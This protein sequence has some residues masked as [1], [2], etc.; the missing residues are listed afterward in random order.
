MP[1][2]VRRARYAAFTSPSVKAGSTTQPG[3]SHPATLKPGTCM[4]RA[5]PSTGATT[6][7]GMQ[8][9]AM[10]T[11]ITHQS[12]HRFLY[13][14]ATIPAGTPARMEIAMPMTPSWRETGNDWAIISATL[15]PSFTKDGPRSP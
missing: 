7:A 6:K 12:I 11:S 8:M 13:S 9:P 1:P 4:P 15:T 5:T 2:R 3:E 14:A 10:E